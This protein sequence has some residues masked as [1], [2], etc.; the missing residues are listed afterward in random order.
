M[1]KL[2][3]KHVNTHGSQLIGQHYCMKCWALCKPLVLADKVLNQTTV[4]CITIATKVNMLIASKEHMTEAPP[5]LV[6]T[7][8]FLFKTI[9][10][11]LGNI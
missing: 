1:L 7:Y 5:R 9:E 2:V 11:T 4:N 10:S 3:S 8:D 6:H